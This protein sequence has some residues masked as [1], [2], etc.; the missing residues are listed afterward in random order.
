MSLKKKIILS[1]VISASIIAALAVFEYLNYVE[2]RKEITYLELTDTVRS[3]SLQLRRH[4]KNFFLYGPVKGAGESGEVRRYIAEL[5]GILGENLRIDRTGRLQR[6]EGLL[7]DYSHRFDKIEAEYKTISSALG[8]ARASNGSYGQF[9]PLI[10]MTFL[11]RP[12]EGSDFLEKVF[13]LPHDHP[14]TSGLRVMDSDITELRKT[15]EDILA[16]SKDLDRTA[17]EN[18]E[19]AIFYSQVALLTSFPLFL[20]VGT[21]RVAAA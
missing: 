16:V 21:P 1:F 2:M 14:L 17:R 7:R 8:V 12:L 11:E 10:E 18:V 9:F 20:L 6:F 19:R 13:R 3:K 4:E 5:D 15:G